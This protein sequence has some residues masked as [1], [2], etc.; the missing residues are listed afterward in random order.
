MGRFLVLGCFLLAW[1]VPTV[2]SGGEP[3][4]VPLDPVLTYR[5]SYLGVSCGEMTLESSV[6]ENKP[7]LT[8]IVMTVKSNEMFDKIYKVRS[9]IESLYGTGIGTS[10]RYHEQTSEKDKTKE[11][12]WEVNPKE[13]IAQRTK[14]G[15]RERIEIPQGG[16]H[17]PLALLYR[18]RSDVGAPGDR[19]EITVMTSQGAVEAAATA[20]RWEQFDSPMGE[21]S[22]LKVVQEPIPDGAFAREG[23]MTMWLAADEARTPYRIDFDLS[24]GKLVAELIS[25]SEERETP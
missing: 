8:R 14:N 16:A 21:V 7:W 12:L 23:G 11:D 24:F 20:D 19:A 9:R 3:H 22:G 2:V 13:G 18:I 15:K 5:I 6:V 10:R 1:T 4:A 25:E 17:D